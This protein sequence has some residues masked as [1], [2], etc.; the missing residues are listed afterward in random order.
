MLRHEVIFLLIIYYQLPKLIVKNVEMIDLTEK[1]IKHRLNII[2]FRQIRTKIFP[3]HLLY[4]T[5][6]RILVSFKPKQFGK[7]LDS[8]SIINRDHLR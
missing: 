7:F 2:P 6:A 1:H 5:V 8:L 4:D 3:V